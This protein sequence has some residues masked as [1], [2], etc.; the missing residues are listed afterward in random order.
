MACFASL[1]AFG[2]GVF[3]VRHIDIS[4]DRAVL[5]GKDSK[6][7]VGDS[8]IVTTADSKQCSLEIMSIKDD[9]VQVSTA[10]CAIKSD[11]RSGQ[12]A[13]LSMIESEEAK[14]NTATE[15]ESSS[16]GIFSTVRPRFVMLAGYDT[17][18]S[19][20]F[21][22][23]KFTYG[24][25]DYTGETS[26]SMDTGGMFGAEVFWTTENSWG[27]RLGA[28]YVLRKKIKSARS[29]LYAGTSAVDASATYT[30]TSVAL[31]S[32]YGDAAYRWTSFYLPFGLNITSYSFENPPPLLTGAAG[33]V[34][35]QGGVGYIL[36]DHILLEALLKVTTLYGTKTDA[37]VGNQSGSFELGAGSV[38]SLELLAKYMF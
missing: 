36:V 31:F 22:N 16:A 2:E 26:F 30:N 3:K 9:R 1:Q 14:A 10:L 8:L 5:I 33:S 15:S 7:K 23:S 20:N 28:D 35:L 37:T 25:S 12:S 13:E 17:G 38:A 19:I 24:G 11:L 29:I 27:F 34:G 4:K 18:S 21:N 32:I 6:A